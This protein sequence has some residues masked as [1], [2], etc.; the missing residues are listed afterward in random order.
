MGLA[1]HLL[2]GI[3]TTPPHLQHWE[4]DGPTFLRLGGRFLGKLG[5]KAPQLRFPEQD[6]ET[7]YTE[8]KLIPTPPSATGYTEHADFPSRSSL[9]GTNGTPHFRGHFLLGFVL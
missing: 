4:E 7:G 3:L 1:L 5:W 9:G 8:P 2:A 6:R